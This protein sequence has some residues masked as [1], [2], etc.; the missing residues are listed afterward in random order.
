MDKDL[1]QMILYI[2]EI[3]YIIIMTIG[4]VIQFLSF[5]NIIFYMINIFL[6][7]FIKLFYQ[8]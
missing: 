7:Y 1:Y 2:I 3:K 4:Q 8:S 5:L 6:N